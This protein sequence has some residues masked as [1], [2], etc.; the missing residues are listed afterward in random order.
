MHN[1]V[2]APPARAGFLRQW[3]WLYAIIVTIGLV[4]VGAYLG[5]R[6][7]ASDDTTTVVE[8]F[9]A[10]IQDK[11]V[12]AA[13]KLVDSDKVPSGNEAAFLKP[14]AIADGWRLEST[15]VKGGN[16]G[17]D[18]VTATFS[19]EL[20]SHSTDFTVTK[21]NDPRLMNPFISVRFEY[22]PLKY[23]QVNDLKVPMTSAGEDETPIF[24]LLPGIQTFYGDVPG[25]VTMGTA[26]PVEIFEDEDLDDKLIRPEKV[27]AKPTAKLDE[28]FNSRLSRCAESSEPQPEDCPFGVGDSLKTSDG[29]DMNTLDRLDWEVAEKPRIALTEYDPR[30]ERY[31]LGIETDPAQPVR[32]TGTGEDRDGKTVDFT[33]KCSIDPNIWVVMIDD[34]GELEL[35]DNPVAED[36]TERSL[37]TCS[38][39]T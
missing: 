26:E 33:V 22:S 21:G 13:L 10:A 20:G 14:E 17:V 30:P 3:W 39:E 27:S 31:G 24:Q 12:D 15:T 25:E 34:G 16:L 38:D 6:Y 1:P 32:L 19:S 18:T 37:G 36:A 2:P 23:A 4:V 7:L 28:E 5:P 35:T 11:D 8:D 29:I 9:F